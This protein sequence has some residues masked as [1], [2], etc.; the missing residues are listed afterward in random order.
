MLKKTRLLEI[1]LRKFHGGFTI[2]YLDYMSPGLWALQGVPYSVL[3]VGQCEEEGRGAPAPG[4]RKLRSVGYGQERAKERRKE[5][6]GAEER[7]Q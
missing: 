6:T 5:I 3:G 4:K 1:H 7:R 2:C